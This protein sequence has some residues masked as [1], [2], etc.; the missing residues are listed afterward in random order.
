MTPGIPKIIHYCWFGRK[1][2][3]RKAQKYIESWKKFFPDYDVRQWDEDNFNV[4]MIPYTREAYAAGKYAFVSDYARYW[5]LFHYG[6]IYFDTDVEVIASFDDIVA[7]GPFFGIEKDREMISVAPGLG[8]GTMPGMAFCKDMM[9]VFEEWNLSGTIIEHPSCQHRPVP[10]ILV[11][12]TTALMEKN[13]FRR[14]NLFQHVAGFNIYPCDFFDP[15]DDY[16]GK[17][18]VTTNTRS[19]HHYAK[20]W[21]SNYTPLRDRAAKLYHRLQTLITQMKK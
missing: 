21:M 11:E 9:N 4:N 10:A 8:M 2:L 15:L 3:P 16:T 12:E 5:I 17:M 13:G 7:N 19:I 1:P 6:G 20:S 18:Y 14:E